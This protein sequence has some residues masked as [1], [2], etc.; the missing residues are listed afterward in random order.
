LEKSAGRFPALPTF[1][2]GKGLDGWANAQKT[3]FADGVLYDQ[4]VA[5]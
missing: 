5:Q 3:H 4:I 2:V 1:S